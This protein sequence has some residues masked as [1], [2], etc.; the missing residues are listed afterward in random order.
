MS[1]N[2]PRTVSAAPRV[3]RD[4][5]SEARQLPGLQGGPDVS[6]SP[7]D[8][9]R[10]I[11]ERVLVWRHRMRVS[12]ADLAARIGVTRTSIT[13]LERGAQRPPLS[14]ILLIAAALE[15]PDYRTLLPSPEELA[16]AS[17]GSA[18]GPMAV[19][20]PFWP[21]IRDVLDRTFSAPTEHIAVVRAT[22]DLVEVWVNDT[23][24]L[25]PET[26]LIAVWPRPELVHRA[27]VHAASKRVAEL[28]ARR[29][30]LIT[31]GSFDPEAVSVATET[32]LTLINGVAV[33]HLQRTL[34]AIRDQPEIHVDV[35]IPR[36]DPPAPV[37]PDPAQAPAPPGPPSISWTPSSPVRSG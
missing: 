15:L 29:G 17:L 3:R 10:L 25:R 18:N 13:N 28:R 12:Q 2:P 26:V 4:E 14:T 6:V 16:A 36:A 27:A 20:Q 19:D 37:M 8:L 35:R 24:P 31:S 34:G 33:A 30:V 11:G 9:Y 22:E 32:G 21:H 5:G 23:N 1:E 7:A